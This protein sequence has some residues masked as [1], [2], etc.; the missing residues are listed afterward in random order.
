MKEMIFIANGT[1]DPK[2]WSSRVQVSD[3]PTPVFKDEYL[4]KMTWPWWKIW[5]YGLMPW[6]QKIVI[7]GVVV[8]LIRKPRSKA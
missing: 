4:K 8:A 5:F 1:E 3:A 7:D 6:Y 2:K